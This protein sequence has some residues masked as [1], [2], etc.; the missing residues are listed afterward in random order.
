MQIAG[1]SL[2]LLSFLESVK[3]THCA[4]PDGCDIEALQSQGLISC[5]AEACALTTAGQLRLEELR[6]LQRAASF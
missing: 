3:A 5:S 4:V 6:A 1:S 2:L